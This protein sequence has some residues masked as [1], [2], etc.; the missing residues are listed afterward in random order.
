MPLLFSHILNML[1]MLS[2]M[3]SPQ[4]SQIIALAG[5][6]LSAFAIYAILKIAGRK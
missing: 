4:L 1:Q 3:P 5:I 2:E 6:C